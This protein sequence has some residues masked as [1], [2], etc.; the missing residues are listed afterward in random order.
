MLTAAKLR[1]FSFLTC[2]AQHLD[3]KIDLIKK[4][5]WTYQAVLNL[6]FEKDLSPLEEA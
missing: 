5:N 6:F 1:R 3:F 2:K 4:V